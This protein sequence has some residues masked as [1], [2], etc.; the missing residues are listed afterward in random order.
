MTSARN[1]NKKK[2]NKFR[3]VMVGRDYTPMFDSGLSSNYSRF[4]NHSSALH[5]DN[6]DQ[7]LYQ[8]GSLSKD[9][10]IDQVDFF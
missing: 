8:I 4:F 3:S 9:S 7:F 5:G 6:R 1:N 10:D 2:V